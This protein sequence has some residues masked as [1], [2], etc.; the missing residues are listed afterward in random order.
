VDAMNNLGNAYRGK[1]LYNKAIETYKKTLEINPDLAIP[2][3]NIAI[4]YLYQEK[5]NR[6]ALY[7][8]EKALE[9]E[10]DFP[11]ARAIRKKIEELKQEIPL[12]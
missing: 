12:A 10:P 5:D 11:Q 3:V 8:F 7:H 4:I 6:K 2:H 9:I 1:E